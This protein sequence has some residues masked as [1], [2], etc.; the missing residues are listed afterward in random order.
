[1]R[2][3]T[4]GL[5]LCLFILVAILFQT[6]NLP[7]PT[8]PSAPITQGEYLYDLAIGVNHRMR[9]FRSI[10]QDLPWLEATLLSILGMVVW[11]WKLRASPQ[12]FPSAPL[13]PK[14][15]PNLTALHKGMVGMGLLLLWILAESSG[16]VLGI[17]ALSG[18]SI[19][20]QMG[21]LCLA[22]GLLGLGM[23]GFTPQQPLFRVEI[24]KREW[25]LLGL[26]TGIGFALRA[27]QLDHLRVLVDELPFW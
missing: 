18:M 15:F 9:L 27:W 7:D 10:K 23:G 22:L 5:I 4:L 3:I 12:I 21:V 11:Q 17:T 19:H 20:L 26:L 16:Q 25:L 1:M 24:P 8:K 13:P 14:G 6:N 2:H